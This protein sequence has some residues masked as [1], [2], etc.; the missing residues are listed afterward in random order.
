MKERLKLLFPSP[1]YEGIVNKM[2]DYFKQDSH[3]F[4]GVLF[5][6]LVYGHVVSD[7]SIDFGVFIYPDQIKK[8][9]EPEEMH[10]RITYFNEMGGKVH[11]SWGIK[12]ES[13]KIQKGEYA[14]DFNDIKVNLLY[15]GNIVRLDDQLGIYFDKFELN[16]GN[17]FAHC[18]LLYERDD[19][20]K[21][22]AKEYLPFYGEDIRRGR[23]EATK[24]DFDYRIHKAKSDS[25]RGLLFSS[26]F[27]LNLSFKHFLQHLF[28][29][30][31]KYPISYKEWIKY[32]IVDIL[33]KPEL[34]EKLTQLF[35]IERFSAE[36]LE[37]KADFLHKLMEEYGSKD[38]DV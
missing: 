16:I 28:I 25:K 34:Y 27:V 1:K 36:V 11:R 19:T 3:V 33:H 2:V 35:T 26:L 13:S 23:L 7:P 17:L 9:F 5:G 32:Q 12:H 14:V 31:R 6:P 24:K 21:S 10:K 22:L 4:A 8:F 15:K 18:I 20:Y 30:E 38:L 29:K 37:T